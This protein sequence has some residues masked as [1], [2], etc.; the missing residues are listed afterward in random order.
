MRSLIFGGGTLPA[1]VLRLP[2]VGTMQQVVS[3]STSKEE[4]RDKLHQEKVNSLVTSP[5]VETNFFHPKPK[6]NVHFSFFGTIN[7]TGEL[8]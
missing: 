8:G 7:G 6:K 4:G 3:F 5:S 1:G 2:A